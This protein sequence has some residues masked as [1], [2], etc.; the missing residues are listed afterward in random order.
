MK[1][2]TCKVLSNNKKTGGFMVQAKNDKGQTV[3]RHLNAEMRGKNPND[4]APKKHAL[5]RRA[6]DDKQRELHRIEGNIVAFMK[7]VEKSKKDGKSFKGLDIMDDMALTVAESI[8]KVLE[9]ELKGLLTQEA[10]LCETLPL[11]AQFYTT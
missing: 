11:V 1:T 4:D 9:I 10:D 3:T 6:V 2:Y 8:M 7:A 5:I